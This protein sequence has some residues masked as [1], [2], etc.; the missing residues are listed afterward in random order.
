[1]KNSNL[2]RAF[3]AGAMFFA[4]SAAAFAAQANLTILHS[5]AGGANDGSRPQYGRLTVAGSNMYGMTA[6]GGSSDLGTIFKLGTNGGNFGVL[7][8]FTGTDGVSSNPDGM[9]PQG[10]L[11]LGGDK[12]YGMALRGGLTGVGNVFSIGTNGSG[13]SV[14]HSFDGGDGAY[15]YDDLTLADTTLYGST[16]TGGGGYGSIF[17]MNVSGGSFNYLTPF[18]TANNG[19]LGG[20]TLGGS[21]LFGMTRYS[22]TGVEGGSIFRVDA[23]LGNFNVIHTFTGG[24]HD[25]LEPLNS[26]LTLYGSTLYG[27]TNG[28]G[29]NNAGTIFKINQDG[30]GFSVLHSFDISESPKG[31]L[32]L[33]G[34]TLYGVTFSGAIYGIDLNSGNYNVV[35]TLS[36][37]THPVGGLTLDGSTLYGMTSSGGQYG[38]G[39]VYALTVPEPATLALLG[40]GGLAL[41]AALWRRSLKAK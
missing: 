38:Y 34:S 14:L 30:S 12:L 9:M 13:F 22:G 1:M 27:V 26:T 29:V 4:V 33:V 28:G 11:T 6:R 16:Y 5:F 25:G 2:F 15:P 31:D 37:G 36:P 39:M 17:K 23:N 19:P 41:L 10:G 24:A 8:S 21:A 7:H 20:L 40:L 32:T 3:F 18:T 35:Y